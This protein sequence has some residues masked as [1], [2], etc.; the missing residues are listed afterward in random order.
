[1]AGNSASSSWLR[2]ARIALI[3]PAA[4]LAEP[5]LAAPVGLTITA[6]TPLR[7]GAFVVVANGSRT[8]SASGAVTNSGIFP[9]NSAPVGPG[10]FTVTY[11]RG[12]N[13]PHVLTVTFQLL[14]GGVAPVN[15]AGVTGSLSGF[16][17]DLPGASVLVPGRAVNYTMPN[18][19]AR[20]CSVTFRIGARIDVTRA[21]G[22]ASLTIALPVTATLISA[23]RL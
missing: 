13:N 9:V 22:G 5:S 8:V 10:Q 14:L 21:S 7:F 6:D 17:S 1:M 15:Q 18:C 2:L 4:L 19:A 12:N 16:V 3:T 11:D 20:T 23:E